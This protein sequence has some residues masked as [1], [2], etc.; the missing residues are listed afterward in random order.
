MNFPAR[1]DARGWRCSFQVNPP[2]SGLSPARNFPAR[3]DARGWRCSFQVNPP[4]SSLPPPR[5]FRHALTRA[6]SPAP[7]TISRAQERPPQSPSAPPEENL[8]CALRAQELYKLLISPDG[9][10]IFLSRS[11]QHHPLPPTQF[12]AHRKGPRDP[13]APHRQKIG[14]AR[15]ARSTSISYCFRQMV[16]WTFCLDLTAPQT[17]SRA[18]KRSPRSPSAT[19]RILA[20]RASHAE[21]L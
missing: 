5:F 11:V 16:K 14:A 19:G 7:Q 21:P 4:R 9:Q 20:L 8:R 18:H 12:H 17:I 10:V 1:A 15:F 3:A 13:P 2:R 6:C